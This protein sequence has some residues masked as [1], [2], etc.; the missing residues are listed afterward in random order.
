MGRDDPQSLLQ[1]EQASKFL[2]KQSAEKQPSQSVYIFMLGLQ[3]LII[4][5]FDIYLC[6]SAKEFKAWPWG[7]KKFELL[8]LCEIHINVV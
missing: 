7:N 8:K 1:I 2:W 4:I 6:F 3:G 5:F